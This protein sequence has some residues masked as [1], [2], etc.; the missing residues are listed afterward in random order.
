MLRPIMSVQPTR[1]SMN[2]VLYNGVNLTERH[3]TSLSLYAVT[4]RWSTFSSGTAPAPQLF[5]LPK[6]IDH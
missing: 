2:I 4:Q 1:E 3:D 6:L 5:T